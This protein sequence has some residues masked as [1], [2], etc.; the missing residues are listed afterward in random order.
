MPRTLEQIMAINDE[1]GRSF[2]V[3]PDKPYRMSDPPVVAEED[4]EDDMPHRHVADMPYTLQ[5]AALIAMIYIYE[6]IA[7]PDVTDAQMDTARD[8][9]EAD[10]ATD[11]ETDAYT[12]LKVVRDIGEKWKRY[13]DWYLLLVACTQVRKLDTGNLTQFCNMSDARQMP[14]KVLSLL[15]YFAAY[16]PR[17]IESERL[18]ADFSGYP[19]FEYHTSA[20]STPKLV[21]KAMGEVKGHGF[22]SPEEAETVDQAL[23]HV[24]DLERTREIDPNT[25]VKARA[26]L[27]ANG[28]LPEVW[29]MGKRAVDNFSGKKYTAMVKLFKELFNRQGKTDDLEELD[30]PA[31]VGRLSALVMSVNINDEDVVD[32]DSE[33]EEDF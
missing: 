20:S 31:L 17:L 27:E 18:R 26:I 25:L 29:Y 23:V 14:A 24:F 10:G 12:F 19:Y 1:G 9:A 15:R 32:D 13:S 7:K 22:F 11:E 3:P 33:E 2:I 5:N 21:D 8:A 28:T 16:M 4:A 6:G 30:E